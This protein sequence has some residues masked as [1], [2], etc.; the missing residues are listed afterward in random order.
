MMKTFNI[1]QAIQGPAYKDG[2]IVDIF[3]VSAIDENHQ[4][5]KLQVI[6]GPSASAS[7]NIALQKTWATSAWI[8]HDSM[9]EL[10]YGRRADSPEAYED[11]NFSAIER[12]IA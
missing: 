10:S 12:E 9:V 11:R 8:D 3:L 7:L 4:A 6:G 1:G 2:P 5:T